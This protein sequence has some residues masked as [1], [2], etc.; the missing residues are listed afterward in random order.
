MPTNIR[1]RSGS[2]IG[3]FGGFSSG[4]SWGGSGSS[5]NSSKRTSRKIGTSTGS[6]SGY[7]TVCCNFQNKINSFKTLVAQ[8]KGPGKYSR[9][10]PATLN[11]FANWINKGAIIQTVSCAQIAR[12]AKTCNKNWNSSN[13]STTACKNVLSAK[14]GKPT[15]KAVART[16]SGS[17]MVAT[18]P[19]W[20]GRNFS[21][22]RS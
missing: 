4:S 2:R 20:K 21:F 6:G 8:T 22:P 18:S 16:K 17:F 7:K 15:I 1:G 14:F 19:T 12:W 11:T 5:S 9:P 3:N 10:K 13:P